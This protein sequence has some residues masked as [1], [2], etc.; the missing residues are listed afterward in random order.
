ME[1]NPIALLPKGGRRNGNEALETRLFHV[2]DDSRT[3]WHIVS[4]DVAERERD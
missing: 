3:C 2:M 1:D 4:D